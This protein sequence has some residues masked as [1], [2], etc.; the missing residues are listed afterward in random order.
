MYFRLFQHPQ[1]SSVQSLSP[2]LCNPMDCSTPG[3]PVHHQLLEFTQT[4]VL[5]VGDAIQLSHLL[6]S[7]YPPTFNLFQHQ[8]QGLSNESFHRINGQSIGLSASVSVPPMDIQEWFPL[9]QTG[10]NSLQSKGLSKVFSN[11]TVQKQQFFS[12]QLSLQSNSHMT[13]GKTIAL[14]KWTFV[15]KVMSLLFNM[16]SIY[17]FRKMSLKHA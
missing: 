4:H 16:L 1:F 3:F 10:W 2:T 11:I 14:T 17:G 5:W 13:T 15:G 9:G 6:S 8:H 7:P 12:A